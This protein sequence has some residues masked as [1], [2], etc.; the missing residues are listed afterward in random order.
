MALTTNW[1]DTYSASSNYYSTTTAPTSQRWYWYNSDGQISQSDRPPQV[2]THEMPSHNHGTWNDN[3][4][5][6]SKPNLVISNADGEPIMKFN[7]DV[8]MRVG[9]EWVNVEEYLEK[10]DVLD[11]MMTMMYN[12]LS[13]WQKEKIMIELNQSTEDDDTEHLDPDLFKV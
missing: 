4:R 2:H 12:T 1:N 13:P 5:V 6:S 3:W 11:K 7:K 9:D 8:Q 10:I